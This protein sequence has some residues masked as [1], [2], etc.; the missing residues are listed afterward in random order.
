MM[1]SVWLYR[2]LIVSQ[3]FK[4]KLSFLGNLDTV[5]MET[6]QHEKEGLKFLC[7]IILNNSCLLVPILSTKSESKKSRRKPEGFSLAFIKLDIVVFKL[8]RSIFRVNLS[9]VNEASSFTA[10]HW[11]HI[12]PRTQQWLGSYPTNGKFI[13]DDHF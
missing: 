8:K 3:K 13:P 10:V 7:S 1:W 12:N 2:I 6:V 4:F 5:H 9:T 11:I